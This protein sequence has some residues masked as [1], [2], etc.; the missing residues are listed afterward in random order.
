ML[1]LC[2][3]VGTFSIAAISSFLALLTVFGG[4]VS[5]IWLVVIGE[6]NFVLAGFIFSVVMPAIFAVAC[7]PAIALIALFLGN[8]VSLNRTISTILSFLNAFW[9]ASLISVWTLFVFHY[10]MSNSN[11]NS[12]ILLSLFGYSITMSPLVYMAEKEV[13]N[14]IGTAF[15][16]ILAV[17]LYGLLLMLFLT[18]AKWTDMVLSAFCLAALDAL[19]IMIVS[20]SAR[21]FDSNK[22]YRASAIL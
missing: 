9:V 21:E 5:G 8:D 19:A 4:I 16:I 22:S 1:H 2:K 6:W 12:F 10:F 3:A 18:G 15:G 20:S 17:V 7:L 11:N 13:E 14:S